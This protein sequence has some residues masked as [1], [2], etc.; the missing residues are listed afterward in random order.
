MDVVCMYVC[1]CVSLCSCYGGSSN[2]TNN[3]VVLEVKFLV[4]GSGSSK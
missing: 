2:G 1:V 4:D 3:V